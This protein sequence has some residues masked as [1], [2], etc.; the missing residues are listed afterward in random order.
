VPARVDDLTDI[1]AVDQGLDEQLA[2]PDGDRDGRDG[3]QGAGS[4]PASRQ[5][6]AMTTLSAT[7][8]FVVPGKA[9]HRA[10]V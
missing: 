10:R 4:R 8:G 2:Q 5:A 1:G 6:A 9:S 7:A 3:Q